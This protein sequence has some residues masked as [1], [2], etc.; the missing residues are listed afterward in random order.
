MKRAP[1]LFFA[2]IALLIVFSFV[3][4]PVFS[5]PTVSASVNP[6]PKLIPT[7]TP[8]EYVMPYP[9][10][11]PTHPLYFLKT[12]RDRIIELLISDQ[13]SKA[14]FYILQGDKKIGMAAMLFGQGKTGDANRSL[15]D[16]LMHRTRAVAE[17]ESL[18]KTNKDIPG[19]ITEKLKRS[20]H[21]HREIMNSFGEDTQSLDALFTRVEALSVDSL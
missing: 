8:V 12:I 14:E 16:A 5:A 21:K 3:C 4:R 6:T 7:P 18:K 1:V 19:H 2:V 10:I 17:L 11:L 13:A 15:A 9:G 20:L